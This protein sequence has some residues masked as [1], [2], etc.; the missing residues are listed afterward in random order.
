MVKVPG[1]EG[2]IALLRGA[3]ARGGLKIAGASLLV[4]LFYGACVA[5]VQ[6]NEWGVEQARFGLKT[7][8]VER[9]FGPGLWFV[10][11]GTTM[12]TFPREIHVLEASFDQAESRAKARGDAVQQ[13]DAYFRKRDKVLGKD[14][15]RAVSY[16]HLTLPT[17]REV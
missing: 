11:F 16:T 6:P 13:V 4:V 8:I 10:P 3:V 17:N 14:T 12:H 2:A 15:H 9:R 7:G 5:R 1:K